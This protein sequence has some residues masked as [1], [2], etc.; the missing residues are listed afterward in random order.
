MATK[1]HPAIVRCRWKRRRPRRSRHSHRCGCGDGT[2]S[3][4]RRG[5]RKPFR[6]RLCNVTLHSCESLRAVQGQSCG[7]HCISPVTGTEDLLGKGA[8]C[9]SPRACAHFDSQGR[10]DASCHLAGM[11]MCGARPACLAHG[12]SG[13]GARNRTLCRD[14]PDSRRPL[15]S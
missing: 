9:K 13:C 11:I 3:D 6:W 4:L 12:S 10:Q 14:C 8:I 7:Q 2:A 5:Y 15:G 1:S